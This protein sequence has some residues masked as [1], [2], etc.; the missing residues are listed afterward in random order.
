MLFLNTFVVGAFGPL[1]PEIG[2]AERLADW[3]LGVLAGA[4]GFARMAAD[5]PA[6]ALAGRRL[7]TTLTVAPA[8]L[9][10]GVLL[11]SSAGSFLVLVVG[12][13]ALG[14]AHTLGMVGGLTAILRDHRTASGAFRLNLF[15][16]AGMLGILGGLAAVGLL[17][18][19]WGWNRSF[20]VASSPVAAV[21]IL[22]PLIRQRFPDAPEASRVGGEPRAP[23]PGVAPTPAIVWLMFAVGTVIAL[24]WSSVS[25]FLIPV[26]GRREF[27]LDRA[28][29]SWVLAVAQLVD[30][31]VLLPVGRLADRIPKPVVLGVVASVLG[32]GT[33]WVG[34]G[35]FPWFVLGC[36]CFGLGL[37]GWML[38]LGVIREHTRVEDLA[39]RTGVYRVGVDAAIF[40]G[41]LLSGALGDRGAGVFASAVGVAAL[42]V[43]ARLL[44]PPRRWRPR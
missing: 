25:Q 12:R 38:P 11:L 21:L 37:A 10:A 36:A 39:W 43:G 8:T 15:E 14:L 40:L 17:P 42:A 5:L 28:G 35:S 29:V 18:E 20:L 9:A 23:G 27:G 26:R 22:V 41:P 44:W 6:G 34:V 7:G 19:G 3:Q 16:F 32:L 4:F 30:L 33:V 1:L 13:L 2:R 24:A 31:A